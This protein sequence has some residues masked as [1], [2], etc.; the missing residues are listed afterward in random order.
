VVFRYA[1]ALNSLLLNRERTVQLGDA[2]AVFWAEA[3]TPLEQFASDLFDD[4]SSH[5]DTL[6]SEDE[7]RARQV[8]LFISQLRDGTA[9]RQAISGA[10]TRFFILGLAPNASRLS[11]RFWI[12]ASV[13]EMQERLGQHIRD[14]E[15]AGQRADELPPS[16]KRVVRATGRA[17]FK[18]GRFSGFD[19]DSVSPMLAAALARAILTG[20]PYPASLLGAMISRLRADGHINHT[21]VAAIKACLTRNTRLQR[22][23]LEV[24]VSLDTNRVEPG[25][26]IGRLFAVLEKTQKDSADGELNSTIKDRFYSSASATPATVFPRLLRLSQHHL[27]KLDSGARIGAERRITEI[28]G[29]LTGFSSHLDLQSQGLFAVGYYHQVQDLY[30]SRKAKGDA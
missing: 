10:S 30:S 20:G 25:Y 1:N 29:K 18:A 27:A 26:L 22:Q 14:I 23:P 2:T 4:R 19:D 9:A 21:R 13:A 5:S 8:R 11:V 17:E 7:E 24:P 16:V 6:E 3:P 12:D 15:L 28:V